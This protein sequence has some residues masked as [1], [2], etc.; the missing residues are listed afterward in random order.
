[1]QALPGDQTCNLDMCP[2]QESAMP[3]GAWDDAPTY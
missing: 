3:F 2:D 1:M